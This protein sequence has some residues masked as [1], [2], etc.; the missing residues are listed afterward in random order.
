MR[1]GG[2]K[3]VIFFDG[4]HGIRQ[5]F[6]I[7]GFRINAQQHLSEK[8]RLR[9]REVVSPV[10]VQ[11][12]SVLADFIKEIVGHVFGQIQLPITQQPGLDEETVPAIHLVEA[13]ARHHVGIGQIEQAL[14]IQLAR[15]V[16]QH[17]QLDLGECGRRKFLPELPRNSSNVFAV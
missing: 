7:L 14:L 3:P 17:A 15:I 11:D 6:P 2:P 13:A 8:R 12:L 16:R 10:G 1:L 4:G 9:T 5:P